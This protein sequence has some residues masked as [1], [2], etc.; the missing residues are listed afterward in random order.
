MK[1]VR[2]G[3]SVGALGIM[4]LLAS[5]GGGDGSSATTP[6][7]TPTPTSPTLVS[8]AV[9]PGAPS[10]AKGSTQ[11]FT[12]TGTY[13]DSSTKALTSGVTWSSSNTSIAT[14]ASTGVA[15]AVAVGTTSITASTSSPAVTSPA[16]TLTVTAP[17]LTSIAVTPAEVFVGQTTQL[18]ATGTYADNSTA[19][20]STTVTWT[21]TTPAV[22]T[23]GAATGVATGVS[24]GTTSVAA[25]LSGIV[26]PGATLTVAPSEYAYVSDF[27]DNVLSI[28][29]VGQGGGLVP[30]T[31]QATVATGSQPYALAVDST[32]HYLYVANYNGDQTS[33]LSQYDI[34]TN[35]TLT[36]MTVP[37]VAAG[38]GPNALTVV[39][40]TL[41]VA[42]Y[43]GGINPGTVGQY[44]IG[45]N[46]ELTYV[47]AYTAGTGTA[48]V[49]VNSTDSVA[50]VT[51]YLA[52][53]ISVFSIAPGGAL[54]LASTTTLSA[55]AGPV[56]LVLDPTGEYAYVSELGVANNPG[57]A[58][59]QFSVTAGTGALVPLS[60][61][62]VATKNNPRWLA[63]NAA[64]NLLFV[65]DAGANVVQAF[66]LGATSGSLG[67]AGA[68]TN[69]ATGVNPAFAVVDPTDQYLYVSNRGGGVLG[70]TAP[71]G[72]SLSQYAIGAGGVLTPLSAPTVTTGD[73]P[74][75]ILVTTA[76]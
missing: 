50:Y 10:I 8:I 22:A 28:Y 18:L 30:N 66:S 69:P 40:N 21:S 54:T 43:G 71:F 44:T 17:A 14:I 48:S 36:A 61:A 27:A 3:L 5:C 9:T 59:A 4:A 23:V 45:A 12:A 55:D 34:A 46:G 41:Y 47:G 67:A 1:S 15:T 62:T 11:A 56:D 76:N 49:T 25:S 6:T 31:T 2:F 33:T 26:S 73:E 64:G 60:T 52:G 37:S 68:A 38:A 63:L 51:N 39:G 65:P 16:V 42:N 72:N 75:F 29:N 32:R 20:I 58:I 35:G 19:N 53:T 13:S 74:A 24:V 70:L 57:S 7:P